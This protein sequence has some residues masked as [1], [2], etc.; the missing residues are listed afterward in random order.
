MTPRYQ[1]YKQINLTI[2][3]VNYDFCEH[4]PDDQQ[5]IDACPSSRLGRFVDGSLLSLSLNE[6]TDGNGSV[7]NDNRIDVNIG[8]DPVLGIDQDATIFY[9]NG[10]T[11]QKISGNVTVTDLYDYT[12]TSINGQAD[13]LMRIEIDAMLT[14]EIPITGHIVAGYAK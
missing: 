14:G 2:D 5:S 8:V 6:D 12:Y 7:L 13:G 11:F 1:F 3:G 9:S 10:Q 4:I